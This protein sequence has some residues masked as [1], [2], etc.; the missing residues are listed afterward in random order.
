[1]CV[2]ICVSLEEK[3]Y[4]PSK[5]LLYLSTYLFNVPSVLHGFKNSKSH[6]FPPISI[7]RLEKEYELPYFLSSLEAFQLIQVKEVVPAPAR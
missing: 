1:M 2:C 6:P 7:H 5:G 4:C 3:L